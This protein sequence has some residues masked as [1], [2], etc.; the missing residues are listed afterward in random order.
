MGQMPGPTERW[1]RS[2]PLVLK[3]FGLEQGCLRLASLPAHCCSN[4]CCCPTAKTEKGSQFQGLHFSQALVPHS[5]IL[6]LTQENIIDTLL[7]GAPGLSST[8]SS[9]PYRKSAPQENGCCFL[10]RLILGVSFFFFF[11]Q[12][13]FWQDTEAQ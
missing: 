4:S 12:P 6:E 1:L 7:P 3:L 11:G 5:H 2:D 10:S 9:L 13:D 8:T